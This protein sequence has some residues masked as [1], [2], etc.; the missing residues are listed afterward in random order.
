MKMKKGLENVLLVSANVAL[1][2]KN[3]INNKEFF[4][5]VRGKRAPSSALHE[6][7]WQDVLD[8]II[9]ERTPKLWKKAKTTD[10]F[11]HLVCWEIQEA[12]CQTL[13]VRHKTG[14]HKESVANAKKNFWSVI[15][16]GDL[17][18]ITDF[19]GLFYLEAM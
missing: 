8:Y 1:A 2:F 7:T 3:I 10:E 12:F 9:D 6:Q 19:A 18:V 5:K 14:N 11:S 16:D 4:V 13:F 17:S 15:G